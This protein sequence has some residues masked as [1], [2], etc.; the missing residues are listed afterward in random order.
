M[1]KFPKVN[2]ATSVVNRILNAADELEAKGAAPV[3]AE[4]GAPNVPDPTGLGLALDADIA[5]PQ[6]PLA[7]TDP[8]MTTDLVTGPLFP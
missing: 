5:S 2:V 8:E 3:A 7:E 6:G 4:R 1:I